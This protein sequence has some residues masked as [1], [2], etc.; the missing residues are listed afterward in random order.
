MLGE[1]F[2]S[3]EHWKK[4]LVLISQCRKAISTSHKDMYFKLVPVIYAQIEQLPEDFFNA[5]LSR[6]NFISKCMHDLI[7]S[8]CEDPEISIHIK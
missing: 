4:L 5:E 2:D 6:D 7:S 3:F 1:N 8:V